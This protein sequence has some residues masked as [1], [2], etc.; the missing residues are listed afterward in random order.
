MKATAKTTVLLK[1]FDLQ[2]VALLKTDLEN[3]KV[4]KKAA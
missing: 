2:L 3:F 4:V 1:T